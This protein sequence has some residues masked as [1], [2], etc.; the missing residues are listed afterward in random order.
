MTGMPERRLRELLVRAWNH[1]RFYR[2][3]YTREGIRERDLPY[4]ALEQLPV[5]SK[6]D[7]M[8]RFDE[9]VTDRRLRRSDLKA[10]FEEDR[11]P[12]NLYLNEYIVIHSSG[13]SRIYSYVPYTRK[14]W[15]YLTATAASR[16][17]PL[18][19]DMGR[20]LRSAFFM[21]SEGHFV[22]P[23]SIS[24]ASQ[25]AHDVLRVSIFDP[26]EEIWARL[27][28]FQPE[29]ITTYAS[30]LS[31]LAEWTL[32]GRL[33]IAPRSVLVSGDRLTP[34]MR[35]QIEKAWN[36]EICDLYAGV[37][38]LYMAARGPRDEEFHVFTDLNLLEVVDRTNRMVRPG[39]R[40]RVLLTSLVHT[41]LPIIRF[42]LRDIAVLGK[43]GTGA[44]TLIALE[45]KEQD[46]LPVRLGSGGIAALAV[47]ELAQVELPGV[48]KMQ[49][50]PHSPDDV[51]IRYQSAHNLDIEIEGAF[52]R[53]LAPKSAAVKKL[54]VRRVDRIL[55]EQATLKLRV[56]SPGME[57]ISPASLAAEDVCSLLPATAS[58]T[59]VCSPFSAADLAGSIED[60]FRQIA[61]QHPERPA[62][63]DREMQLTYGELNERATRVSG[64][65][66][67]RGFDPARPVAVL[68]EH[69]LE[70]AP[71]ILGVV[72]A[73][74][75]Y[76]PL[77]PYLPTGRL[78]AILADARPE[79]VLASA[80]QRE[81]AATLAG[82]ERTVLCLDRMEASPAHGTATLAP[83]APAC[84]LYTSGTTGIPK[85]VVLSHS[86]V[87][88]RAARY[89]ADY[90]IHQGDRLSLLQSFAVSAGIREIYGALLTGATLM[91][92][93]IRARGLAE[94]AH[95][96]DHTGITV[97]YAVPT[98]FRLFL[99]TLTG[100]IFARVR[101]VR[102]GGEP[103]R[104][105]DVSG[106]RRHFRRGC[107]LANGY[108]ATETDT[109][110]QT[111]FD[112]DTRIVAGRVPA[113]TPVSG[114]E[115]TLWD[116]E[117]H[118][119]SGAVGEIRVASK[120]LASGYW[121]AR[122]GQVQPF[123]V[124]IATGDLGYQLENGS[125]FLLGRRDLIV[126]V[127]GYRIHLSEIERAA[128]RVPGVVEAVAVARPATNGDTTIVVYYAAEGEAAPNTAE[129]RRAV[130]AV[131]PKPAE[132]TAYVKLPALPRLPG[133]KVNRS[134]LVT[135]SK[136][137]SQA[138]TTEPVYAS[139]I[140]RRV[141][142]IWRDVLQVPAPQ[143]EA[144]FFD[145]GGD[146]VS[147]FRLLNRIEIDFGVELSVSE[148]CSQPVLAAS[149]QAVEQRR[150]TS[151]GKRSQDAQHPGN[152]K[153]LPPLP[154]PVTTRAASFVAPR[155]PTEHQI[156]A[157]WEELFG[158]SPI[159][160]HDN[161][162]DLGGDSMFAAE[163]VARVER[164]C[165]TVLSPSLLAEAPTVADLAEA[166]SRVESGFNEPVTAL[167]AS[168][169][170][171]PLFFLHNDYGRG[172]YTHALARCLDSDRP[173]YAVHLHGLAEPECPATVEA[174]A[175]SRIEAVRGTRP[176]GPYVLGGHCDGGLIA[177]EMARQ[178]HG[179]GEH[180]EL[181]VMV[182][183]HA[184]SRGFPTLR[185]ASNVA[186]QLRERSDRVWGELTWR[187][188]YYKTRLETLRRASVRSQTDYVLR[189]LTG[190][191]RHLATVR[192]EQPA[193]NEG[194]LQNST[195]SDFEESVRV[196]R[197]AVRRYVPSRY[198]NPVI[199]F[200][201]EQFPAYRPDLGWSRL[202][203]RL[204]V[205]VIPGDHHTC[206]TRH[207]TAFGGSLNEILRRADAGGQ[208]SLR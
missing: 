107:I 6:A 132:P 87:L 174:I 86:A 122:S 135:Q 62:A 48:E 63:I 42:D 37:E 100:E 83:A 73:G 207:V 13:G 195:R 116:E 94:L 8:V 198:S 98:I 54:K 112:H 7:L 201:S 203:P 67:R 171:S 111:F 113:G 164:T 117:G 90:G 40:G 127:H 18:A 120:M 17:L 14:A 33:R 45:G 34:A 194:A 177:L 24:L 32:E 206:I 191:L 197:R 79:F 76:V 130:A 143:R 15:R 12:L 101:V 80:A 205:A 193:G 110:C 26:V 123:D 106:F 71:L 126:N 169:Q 176:H 109:I 88:A 186:G 49:F 184:P 188:R 82:P 10:W 168:G 157:I 31:W 156:A 200:R 155:S 178:L 93:D 204:E 72:G 162:F 21:R 141:A 133:G 161:Y 145:L 2:E 172:L 115:V 139:A 190:S 151:A 165:G 182:D 22:G 35:A 95:W 160:A 108:A 185:R 46:W 27:N 4:I 20:P 55:N 44:E 142:H 85:G 104:E 131:I 99:E 167:R 41:T 78:Q 183:T 199:L 154:R 65:L 118:S 77:D 102:L 74:G 124:P 68:C 52:R 30:T 129:I 192:E 11:D 36:P 105:S 92:Y 125:V 114:V 39:E 84:L 136:S 150:D 158:V 66:L 173:F 179:A 137:G 146:S 153:A 166:M 202:L 180:V 97:F 25:A 53:L 9:A 144:N 147:V 58:P 81:A 29:R 163:F 96:L 138:A 23:T 170:R 69:G 16:L 75:F 159:G 43:V 181:V 140:E 50:I 152:G 3:V 59:G 5:V 103:V 196:H 56:V 121:D 208:F 89:A 175:A 70:L 149:A 128:S 60:R 51:E 189:K 47:H 134:S 28:A 64:E 61:L 57:M 91:F 187:T 1:S 19:Q 148:F 38:S 119:A